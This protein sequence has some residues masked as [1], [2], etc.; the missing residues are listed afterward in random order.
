MERQV[1]SAR[2]LPRLCSTTA[3]RFAESAI[4]VANRASHAVGSE[5]PSARTRLAPS[6]G[7]GFLAH[8]STGARRAAIPPFPSLA[9]RCRVRWPRTSLH[10]RRLL[11]VCRWSGP[12]T[13]LLDPRGFFTRPVCR[14]STL[15]S[16][17]PGSA[18]R[19]PNPR[20]GAPWPCWGAW[21]PF[22]DATVV[23]LAPTSCMDLVPAM[24]LACPLFCRSPYGQLLPLGMRKRGARSG[25]GRLWEGAPSGASRCIGNDRLP[26]HLDQSHAF[27]GSL[28]GPL[29][30]RVRLGR[31]VRRPPPGPRARRIR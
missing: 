26:R 3:R 11:R 18:K 1:Y 17:W 25:W 29:T 31:R 10:T 6:M 30:E 22:L 12:V 8:P 7:R 5:S 4:R 20:P 23:H 13:V 28:G 14:R 21:L 2:G 27:R 19:N 24:A 9:C 15:R 16:L